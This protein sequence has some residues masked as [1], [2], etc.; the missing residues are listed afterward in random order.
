MNTNA[1]TMAAVIARALAPNAELVFAF[2]HPGVLRNVT[3]PTSVVP[4]LTRAQAEQ[5]TA[6]GEIHSGM[7][8]K[9]TAAFAAAEQGVSRVRITRYDHLDG[10]GGSWIR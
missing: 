3:D 4:E 8:P 7:L 6:T 9:L 10:G 1:D 5:M 2:D